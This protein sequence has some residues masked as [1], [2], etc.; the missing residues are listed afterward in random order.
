MNQLSVVSC[1]LS[2][3]NRQLSVGDFEPRKTRKT[4]NENSIVTG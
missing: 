4:R 2:V 3:V 1:Q